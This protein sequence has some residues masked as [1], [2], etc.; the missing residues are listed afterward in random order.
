M[1]SPR[2]GTHASGVVTRNESV[3]R[4]MKIKRKLPRRSGK[5]FAGWIKTPFISGS[6]CQVWVQID[7]PPQPVALDARER[8]GLSKS[9]GEEIEH[10]SRSSYALRFLRRSYLPLLRRRYGLRSFDPTRSKNGMRT[11]FKHFSQ[12]RD[13]LV[14][15]MPLTV[16]YYQRF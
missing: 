12:R 3:D 16:D 13:S 10:F 1:E 15:R 4:A 11:Q 8:G 9:A 14:L 2:A 6:A 5:L 7:H